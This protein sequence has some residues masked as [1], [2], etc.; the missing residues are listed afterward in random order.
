MLNKYPKDWDIKPLGT[1]F[2][3]IV[4]GYVGNIN[5]HYC[6]A[7]NGI[8]F[9]RTLN[10]RD[11]YFRVDEVMYVTKEFNSKNKKSQITNDDILIARVGANLG[12]TCKV[13]GL[14][15]MANIANAIVIKA[16]KSAN[17]DFYT[18]FLL[19]RMGKDQIFSGAGGGAQGVFNTKL[20]Q[21]ITVPVPP[22]E[23]QAKIAKILS[24]WDKAIEATESLLANSQQ[25]KK[26]L[27]QQ[28][29][30]GKKR[31]KGFSGEWKI[32]T[33]KQ[34]CKVSKGEQLNR[35]TLDDIGDYPVISGGI[36]PSGFSDKFNSEANTV[37]ISEGGNS[38]GFVNF[39]RVP[40]WC[41]G[42]CYALLE[43]SIPVEFLYHI[44]KFHEPKIM[45]LRV[46]SGLPNV[47]KKDIDTLK[48]WLPINKNEQLAIAKIISSA[49]TEIETLQC[50]LRCLNQEKKA[51]MQVLLTGK[52][53]VRV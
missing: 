53:R 26:A 11:G 13:Q 20:T 12:M 37:I 19:S 39:M 52:K 30:T 29:L 31:L 25:Q 42:H 10:I 43:T 32:K 16:N 45:K 9:Y 47:Q 38:C 7:R 33:L 21:K 34:L 4:V 44:L 3:K 18:Y 40:F 49:D 50:R 27:M 14:D 15:R 28:L 1:I 8:P 24:T 17:S 35:D 6:D 23:E 48:L 22:C 5:D 36:T 46:G 41:G 2:P 51:L